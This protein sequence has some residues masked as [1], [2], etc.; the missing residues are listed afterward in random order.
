M[1]LQSE[2]PAWAVPSGQWRRRPSLVLGSPGMRR[3]G[4]ALAATAHAG[5]EVL[6]QDA[7]ERGEVG[8]LR[9]RLLD[10]P[11]GSRIR[12]S[13]TAGS[14]MMASSGSASPTMKGSESAR[15][16]WHR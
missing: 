7:A 3:V 10:P 4:G 12:E 13:R 2:S 5:V 9:E 11:E 14:T 8:V 16:C 15:S 1:K 6:G